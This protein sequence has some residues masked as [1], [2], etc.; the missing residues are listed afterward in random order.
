ML[1][2]AVGIILCQHPHAT[3]TWGISLHPMTVLRYETQH[4]PQT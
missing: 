1:A 2:A 4:G 3:V